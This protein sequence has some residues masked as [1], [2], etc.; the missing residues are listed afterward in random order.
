VFSQSDNVNSSSNLTNVWENPGAE[1]AGGLETVYD[2]TNY[3]NSAWFETGFNETGRYFVSTAD[4]KKKCIVKFT[5]CETNQTIVPFDQPVEYEVLLHCAKRT[6][7]QLD[8]RNPILTWE[9]DN[10]RETVRSKGGPEE[11]S[12]DIEIPT[13]ATDKT[14]AALAYST[15]TVWK[16]P[17]AN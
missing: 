8:P 9:V 13:P 1:G 12:F 15:C 17:E 7:N 11:K 16:K 2:E 3:T 5:A 4:V 14:V 10:Q 6:F